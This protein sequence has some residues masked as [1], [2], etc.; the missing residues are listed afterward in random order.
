MIEAIKLVSFH[1]QTEIKQIM[2]MKNKCPVE[3]FDEEIL[4]LN[5]RII[6][7]HQR[8]NSA[9]DAELESDSDPDVDIMSAEEMKKIYQEPKK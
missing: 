6:K 2:L 1:N 5:E 8:K 9:L 3:N 4:R 7:N